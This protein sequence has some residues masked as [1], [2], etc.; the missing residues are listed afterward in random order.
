MD[1]KKIAPFVVDCDVHTSIPTDAL[2]RYLGTD[3]IA[4]GERYGG[5]EARGRYYPKDR[6]GAAR[7]DA[8]PDGG[9][10]GSNL[11]LM[12]HQLLDTYNIDAVVLNPLSFQY[13]PA[14]QTNL[15]YGTAVARATN[16]WTAEEWL[17]KDDRLYGS[18]TIQYEDGVGSVVEIRRAHSSHK[19]FVQVLMETRTNELLGNRRYWPVYEVACE[20]GLTIGVHSGGIGSNPLSGTGWPSFYIE[21]NSSPPQQ[22]QSQLTSLIANGVFEAF[23]ELRLVLVENGIAW[24]PALQERL[25][26]SW[27][28]LRD[29]I[30]N[31]KK[32]P[33][34]YL[35]KNVWLTTQPIEEPDDSSLM[36][37][38]L[39]RTG[40]SQRLLFSTDYP[41]WDFD[42]PDRAIYDIHLPAESERAVMGE[43]AGRLYGIVRS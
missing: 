24:M 34:E 1:P 2:H 3:W 38:L 20:L 13:N 9:I 37:A 21:Q 31:V 16:E 29:E 19:R 17:D 36:R 8:W 28:K 22:A 23:P 14:S 27:E 25:D 18:I 42:A 15:D 32:P 40:L 33:S 41:H 10:P 12:Q 11:K 7:T 6:P 26:R 30:P 4:Y 35:K 39:E 5:R 43:T